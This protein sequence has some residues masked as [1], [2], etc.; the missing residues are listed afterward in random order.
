MIDKLSI[1]VVP[2]LTFQLFGAVHDFQTSMPI[3]VQIKE[4]DPAEPVRKVLTILKR[5]PKYAKDIYVSAKSNDI[6]PIL[7]ACN[8]ECESEYKINAKSSM[9][10]KGLA[11]TP[12]A[13]MKTGFEVA[14]LMYGA[15]IYKEKLQIAKGDRFKALCLY[16]GGLSPAAKRDAQKV[17][18]LYAKVKKQLEKETHNG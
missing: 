15:C 8:I 6:D 16:K 14:D 18:D 2:L 17:Y 13:K 3:P 9:G 11:Q 10:Y 12:K 4:E 1:V 7:W 5:D